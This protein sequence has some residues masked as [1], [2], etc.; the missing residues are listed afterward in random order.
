VS[1]A[2]LPER[3]LLR[4]LEILAKVLKATLAESMRAQRGV[5]KRASGI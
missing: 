4:A 2:H 3:D 5:V 1:Y